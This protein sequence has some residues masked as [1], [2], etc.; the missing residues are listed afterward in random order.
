MKISELCQRA[1]VTKE[2]IRHYEALGLISAS[3]Q[4][5][6]T[7][8]YR[9]FS[10]QTIQRLHL[11]RL[12]K[13]LGFTLREIKPLLDAYMGNYLN[14]TQVREVLQSQSDKLSQRI[15]Q[16]RAMQ[17]LIEQKLATLSARSLTGVQSVNQPCLNSAAFDQ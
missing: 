6:G 12:G 7:R 4:Q 5:A 15:N 3:Q 10:E 9:D 11:I 8:L 1:G 13:Q 16:A 14:D 17:L 2:L